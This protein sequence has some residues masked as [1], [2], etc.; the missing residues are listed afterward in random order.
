MRYLFLLCLSAC[1]YLTSGCASGPWLNQVQAPEGTDD[2]VAFVK[3]SII[4]HAPV[5][6]QQVQELQPD[7]MWVDQECIVLD[8][9]GNQAPC[10]DGFMWDDPL[11]ASQCQIYL[12]VQPSFADSSL[13]H[14]LLHCSL[15]LLFGDS[16]ASHQRFGWWELPKEE[17]M[18]TEVETQVVADLR[19]AGL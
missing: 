7:I 5:D 15:K 10:D 1:E 8:S 13:T 19:V 4:L 12:R 2:A 11:T 3:E 9:V 17:R 18:G 16:D 6:A 14:E